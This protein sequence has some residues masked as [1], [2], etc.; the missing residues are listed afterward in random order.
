MFSKLVDLKSFFV[1]GKL[2]FQRLFDTVHS[3]VFGI[4]MLKRC[5]ITANLFL[6]SQFNLIGLEK[7]KALGV[8]AIVNMRIHDI[9]EQH[10]TLGVKYLHLPTIDNTP[11]KIEDL[12]QGV[13]FIENEIKIGGKVYVHCREGI[14]RGPTMAI[15]YLLKLG[16]TLSD[17]IQLIKKIRPFINPKPSQLSRLQELELFYKST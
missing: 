8:T 2:F 17:A 6:G 3:F 4:P 12:K 9:Y 14:G 11:P 5:Q 13:V 1:V 16:T 7:L 15:A 10:T